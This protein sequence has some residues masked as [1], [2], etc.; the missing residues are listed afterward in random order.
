MS[1]DDPTVLVS[2]TL[3]CLRKLMDEPNRRNLEVKKET[4]PMG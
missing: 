2:T 3:D 1:E 4:E